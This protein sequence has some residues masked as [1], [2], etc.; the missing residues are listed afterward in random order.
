MKNFT[1]GILALLFS[2][3]LSA[4]ISIGPEIMITEILPGDVIE[5]YNNTDNPVDVS[6]YWLCTFPTYDQVNNFEIIC[7]S[8]TI[9]PGET[10]VICGWSIDPL[11]GELGL[12]TINS[13]NSADAIVD[14]VEWGSTGH[15]R[16]SVAIAAGVWTTGEFIPSLEDGMSAQKTDMGNFTS[17]AWQMASPLICQA[18]SN[19]YGGGNGCVSDIDYS[20]HV[21]VADLLILLGEF[22]SNCE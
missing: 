6:D 2:G 16:S 8:Y 20:G 9:P 11:D 7:G 13:F 3:F 22:G 18:F 17:S 21:D 10:L 12:Y 4:Q 1:T 15:Q 14:Y 5:L 19:G